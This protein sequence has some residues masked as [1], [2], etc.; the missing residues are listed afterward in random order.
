MQSDPGNARR[1]PRLTPEILGP[2]EK[3]SEQMFPGVPVV[4][5]MATGATDGRFLTPAGIP[6]TASPAS[7][8]TRTRPAC[9]GLNER[10]GVKQLMDGRMFLHLLVK[11]LCGREVAPTPAPSAQP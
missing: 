9:H 2:I 10:V 4:P 6:P 5:A 1:S 3:I 8:L 7:S 11:D